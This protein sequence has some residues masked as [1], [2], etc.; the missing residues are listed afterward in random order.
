MK[1]QSD[2][3]PFGLRLQE[4]LRRKLDVKAT[5][6]NRSLNSEIASRLQASLDAED[7]YTAAGA[8]DPAGQFLAAIDT[9]RAGM[10]VAEKALL[11]LG[12]AN[13]QIQVGEGRSPYQALTKEQRLLLERLLKADEKSIRAVLDL[14]PEQK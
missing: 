2:I 5:S 9:V 1:K 11:L 7:K 8:G 14:L 12:V 4:D 10:A 6:N 13:G 3:N